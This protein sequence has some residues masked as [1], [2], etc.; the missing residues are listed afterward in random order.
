MNIAGLICSIILCTGG[1]PDFQPVFLY[2][3]TPE[4]TV[5]PLVTKVE[6]ITT[7]YSSVE[8]CSDVCIMA[9]GRAP[10]EG[11]V[12][13]PRSIKLGTEIEI[14]GVPY[15]CSDR[16]AR[17]YD[18]RFDLFAG[19]G[20]TGYNIAKKYGKQIKTVFIKGDNPIRK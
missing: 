7:M 12:A 19:Y 1:F 15:T 8:T 9:N 6:A 14:D 16:T 20:M 13:C 10:Q 18:G 4:T 17:K 2:P 3:K 5:E 11:D